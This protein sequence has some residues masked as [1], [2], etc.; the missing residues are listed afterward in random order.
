MTLAQTLHDTAK[1][2]AAGEVAPDTFMA[3]L[4]DVRNAA[5]CATDGEVITLHRALVDCE[6]LLLSHRQSLRSAIA[7][8]VKGGRAVRGFAALQPNTRGQRVDKKA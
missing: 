5:D 3:L 1:A 7:D 8:T 4:E 2:V 6:P